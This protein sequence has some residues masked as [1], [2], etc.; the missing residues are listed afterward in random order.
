MALAPP[1]RM[2]GGKGCGFKTIGHVTYQLKKAR[3]IGS[4]GREFQWAM[5][6][7]KSKRFHFTVIKLAWSAH[8]STT[9]G[10]KETLESM[11][12]S[13]IVRSLCFVIC[14]DVK[15]KICTS[16]PMKRS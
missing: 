3:H 14:A 1:T 13:V 8:I 2:S 6:N 5:T 7:L 10:L 15:D 4:W 9:F 12:G 11:E 16:K